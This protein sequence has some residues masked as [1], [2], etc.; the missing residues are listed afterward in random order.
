MG[1][2]L[3]LFF[4]FAVS[5]ITVY[6]AYDYNINTAW[7]DQITLTEEPAQTYTYN[8]DGKVVA[9]TTSSQS[10]NTYKYNGPDLTQF[11]S[12][13]LGQFDFT[14][15]SS[16]N[17]TKATN[18][19]I[20]LTAQ[21]D[22]AGNNTLAKLQ[23]GTS[24]IYLQNSASYTSDQNHIASSNDVNN[25]TTSYTY[26]SLGR[27]GSTSTPSEVGN[28]TVNR[29]YVD[30][31]NS[32]SN[33]LYV[34]GVLSLPNT[35]ER[36]FLT[37]ASRKSFEGSNVQWQRYSMP[38]DTWGNTT[39]VQ[40]QSSDN[41]NADPNN[42]GDWSSPITLTSYEYGENNGP[43]TRMEYGNGDSKDYFYDL[44]G[45]VVSV[46]NSSGN[47]LEYVEAY[48]YDAFGNEAGSVIRDG[49]GNILAEYRYEYDSLGRLIRSQQV[50]DSVSPISTQHSYDD[51]NRLK[52]QYWQVSDEA[53]HESYTYNN[54]NGTL[55]SMLLGTG[56]TLSFEY[57][58]LL[59]VSK[60]NVSG[61]YQHRRNYLG[62]GTA[63][64]QSNRIQYYVFASADG[65]DTKMTYRYDYDAAG[66]IVKSVYS[67]YASNARS[68][69]YTTSYDGT[70]GK[71]YRAYVTFYVKDGSIV[72]ND[73]TRWSAYVT[74]Q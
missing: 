11:V 26:D 45:R 57:D 58:N 74:A 62:T 15:D 71:D 39:S 22:G 37:A 73:K 35:Y 2:G 9:V 3:P 44:Y 30:G 27:L 69:S 23:K 60:K 19:G 65:A 54:K 4:Y 1:N 28:L 47:L 20:N 34:S 25:I 33:S 17:M 68:H 12:A 66:N 40:V 56:R 43:M 8:D 16:H 21:Y 72:E 5:T 61:V 49:S 48:S 70:P 36:G 52:D 32:R 53:L 18:D 50:G 7:F 38:I 41:A 63:N 24:G 51:Q 31:T 67:K 42:D 10:T 13:G 64:R 6:L 14:Y 46:E 55:S 29:T 59:R